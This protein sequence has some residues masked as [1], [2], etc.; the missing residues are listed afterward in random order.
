MIE[1]SPTRFRRDREPSS[2]WLPTH[3]KRA[4]LGVWTAGRSE[5]DRA[6]IKRWKRTAPFDPDALAVFATALEALIRAWS[7]I[8]PAGTL[9]T[10]P[11][12]GAS[13]PGPYAALALGRQVAEA[14]GLP[15]AE[16]LIRTDMKRW[17]GPHHSLR[18]APFVCTLPA[19]A[20]TMV[21]V[22][23]DLVTT[24]ATMRRSLEAIRTAGV[25]AF[26]FGFSGV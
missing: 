5:R 9:L 14:L 12:Q 25:A 1:S 22:V 18:Q 10:I 20:P 17:H 26:G 13:A 4:S 3:Q 7:S 15:F 23:D 24:G 2:R 11:P 19:P 8:L 6:A 21:L 16:I